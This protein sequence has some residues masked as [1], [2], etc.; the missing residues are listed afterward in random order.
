MIQI[1]LTIPNTIGIKVTIIDLWQ[2]RQESRETTQQQWY[3]IVT[4]GQ[5]KGTLTM[6]ML[7]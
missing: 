3:R 7:F 1:D 6:E 4:E 2:C 5:W